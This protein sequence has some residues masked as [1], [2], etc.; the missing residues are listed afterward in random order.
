MSASTQVRTL[1]RRSLLAAGG[2]GMAGAALAGYVRAAS[3]AET[4][5][6]PPTL[7]IFPRNYTWSAAVRFAIATLPNGGGDMGEVY[8]VCA[9]LQGKE[10]DNAAWF[11]E[12]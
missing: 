7:T 3:A 2:A 8:K 1:N 11:T 12:W 9:A 10:G 5:P 6:P 4:G